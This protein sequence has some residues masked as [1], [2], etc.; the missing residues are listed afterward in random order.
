MALRL[1]RSSAREKK[2]RR[3]R[4]AGR[5]RKGRETSPSH[6]RSR[7]FSLSCRNGV[8]FRGFRFWPWREVRVSCDPVEQRQELSHRRHHG[9]FVGMPLRAFLAVVCAQDRVPHKGG[10]RR[11]VERVAHVLATAPYSPKPIPG[12]ALVFLR[13]DADEPV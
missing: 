12:P 9:P 2:A 5:R 10:R 3:M 13:R 7:S 8:A 1:L 11:H 4:G 6:V